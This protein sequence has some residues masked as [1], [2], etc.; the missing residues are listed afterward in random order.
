MAAPESYNWSRMNNL[1]VGRYA[2]YLVKME[3][4]LWGHSVFGAEVDDRGIDFVIRTEAGR[5]YDVQVKSTRS[6]N[7]I[8]FPKDKF[9]LRENMLGATVILIEGEPPSLHL[10]PATAWMAPNA[11]LVD[12][13]YEGKKSKP[14]WGLNISHKNMDLMSAYSFDKVVRALS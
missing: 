2:E 12:R 3:F 7:S 5:H 8:F 6:L 10:F 1:Q 11:L 13:D 14:E 4:T 9:E